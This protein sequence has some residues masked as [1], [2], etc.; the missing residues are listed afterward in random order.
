MNTRPPLFRAIAA[1]TLQRTGANG[2][3]RP[4]S[5]PPRCGG[6]ADSTAGPTGRRQVALCWAGPSGAGKSHMGGGVAERSAAATAQPGHIGQ[7][8]WR[9]PRAAQSSSMTPISAPLDEHGLFHLINTVRWSRHALMMT[10]AAVSSIPVPV[11]LADLHIAAEGGCPGRDWR[12]RM[13]RCWPPFMAKL[14]ADRQV[15]VEPHVIEFIVRRDRKI[16]GHRDCRSWTGLDP[17]WRSQRKSR[18]S[19]GVG[20]RGREQLDAGQTALDFLIHTR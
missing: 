5:A 18:I 14:F 11:A 17:P 16:D 6:G 10:R 2:T 19:R 9:P 20:Q 1:R 13:T 4:W 12:T 8:A 7:D 3:R 15:E